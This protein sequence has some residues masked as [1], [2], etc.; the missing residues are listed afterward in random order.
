MSDLE[1]LNLLVAIKSCARDAATGANQAV[2]DTWA[3]RACDLGATVNFFMGH[4]VKMLDE[5][6]VSAGDDYDSLPY[7]TRD[8]VRYTLKSN[9]DFAFLCDT[10][11]Y[12]IPHK[13]FALPYKNFDYSGRLCN[14]DKVAGYKSGALF[15]SAYTDMRKQTVSPCYYWASGG[16]GYFLSRKAMQIIADAEPTH[17]A[18]DLWTGQIL[19][20]AAKRGE[21]NIGTF[22]SDLLEGTA[23]WHMGGR[24]ERYQDVVR[25]MHDMHQGH[26]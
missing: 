25:W 2:R 21:I 26:R 4:G 10:D 18:E 5:V 8:I 23:S 12:L 16:V 6:A 20:A 13:L 7:K 1:S 22:G 17:W 9:Y 14:N 19:G 24:T 11:T 15:A 3:P